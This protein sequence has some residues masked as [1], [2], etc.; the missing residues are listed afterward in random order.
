[1]YFANYL[2]FHIFGAHIH[3]YQNAETSYGSPGSSIES[4]AAS[5]PARYSSTVISAG[6]FAF[7][8][9][10]MASTVSSSLALIIPSYPYLASGV[11]AARV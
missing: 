2:H 3:T 7:R 1:L 9:A 8:S 5:K 10:N 4:A 6:V 11:I